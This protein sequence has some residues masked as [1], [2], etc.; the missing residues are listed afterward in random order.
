M[1]SAISRCPRKSCSVRL[2]GAPCCSRA[3]AQFWHSALVTKVSVRQSSGLRLPPGDQNLGRAFLGGIGVEALAFLVALALAEL[4][5]GRACSRA[6][7]WT[8]PDRPRA[9]TPWSTAC[10]SRDRSFMV[11]L[12]LLIGGR[13]EGSL[14][15]SLPISLISPGF[16]SRRRGATRGRRRGLRPLLLHAERRRRRLRATPVP[17]APSRSSSTADDQRPRA[18]RPDCRIEPS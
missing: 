16:S 9:P 18:A 10:A 15:N 17:P 1:S 7:R 2:M 3:C 12:G 11:S 14:S 5:G 6:R 8:R 13:I 4:I